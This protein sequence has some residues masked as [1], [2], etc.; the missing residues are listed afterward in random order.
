MLLG[1]DVRRS[2]RNAVFHRINAEKTKL[3]MLENMA[4]EFFPIGHDGEEPFTSQAINNL[5]DLLG[6]KI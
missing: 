3:E 2:N 5:F 1:R 6:M 4:H